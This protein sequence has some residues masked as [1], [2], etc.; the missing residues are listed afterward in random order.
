MEFPFISPPAEHCQEDDGKDEANDGG[1][2]SKAIVMRPETKIYFLFYLSQSTRIRIP[3]AINK[4]ID[5]TWAIS[6]AI[7]GAHQ[8]KVIQRSPKPNATTALQIKVVLKAS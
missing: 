6:G 2:D 8:T 5:P 3:R 1:E 4:R 7:L